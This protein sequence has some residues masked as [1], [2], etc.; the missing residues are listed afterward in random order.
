MSVSE[1]LLK[2][3]QELAAKNLAAGQKYIEQF[4]KNPEVTLLDNGI[5][6]QILVDGKGAKPSQ[7]DTVECHY[8]GTNV[9][10]EI[11]DSSVERGKS[12]VFSLKKVIKGWQEILPM[13]SVGS[14]WKVV[15]PSHLAYGEEQISKQIGPNST[16][17]FEIEL[18]DIK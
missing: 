4:A 5:A 18:I 12:A 11:F 9:E 6:Y 14:K 13:M 1:L 7:D 10:N 17:I 2:R 16:L 15:I 3:K 8:H